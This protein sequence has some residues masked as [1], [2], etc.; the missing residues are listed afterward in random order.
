M[1]RAHEWLR[2]VVPILDRSFRDFNIGI[3]SRINKYA[4]VA[5]GMNPDPAGRVL[6][7][8]TTVEGF[9]NAS[10]GLELG[11]VYE[12]GY[13]AMELALDGVEYRNGTSKVFVLVT[14]EERQVIFE[15]QHLTPSVM[16]RRLSDAG[17]I[18]NTVVGQAFLFNGSEVGFAFG[19]NYNGT[20]YAFDNE[21]LPS[22]YVT[23]PNGIRHPDPIFN[24][25]NTYE[26]YVELAFALGGASW[27]IG[28]LQL[29][30]E[31]VTP[32]SQAFVASKIDEV[33]LGR[34]CARCVCRK[35]Q[36]SCINEFTVPLSSCQG[37]VPSS[38]L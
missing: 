18:L 3:G 23:Y 28:Q 20:A 12:D 16:R 30:Q 14:D 11:G 31:L 21:T 19:L 29:S 32:F 38:E 9:L 22:S 27:H 1:R 24:R 25:G 6:S 15:K 33:V 7:Q 26:N 2:Y 37:L 36:K 8:L 4:L 13:A 17:V 5:F 10:G 34:R 35:P